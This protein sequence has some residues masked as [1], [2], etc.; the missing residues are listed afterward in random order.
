MRVGAHSLGRWLAA[1]LIVGV[2]VLAYSNSFRGVFVFD[3]KT[4]IG[5]NPAIRRLWPPGEAMFRGPGAPRRP[6]PYYT[7]ALNYALH[8][9]DVWGYHA[10]NLAIH[11]AAGLTL[12]GLVRRT[13]RRPRL[14]ARYAA[15]ADQIA[16]AAALVWVVHPL[17]TQAVTY[18]YQRMESLM[19]LFYLL[20]LYCFVRSVGSA[21]S[22]LWRQV[23]VLCCAAGMGC[24]EVMVT[25]P[26]LVLWYDRVFVAESWREIPRRRWGFYAAMAATWAFLLVVVRC[27]A[28]RYGELT[29]P[30]LTPWQYALNQ[31]AV[32]LHYLRLAVFPRGLCL[33]HLWPAAAPRELVLP[34]LVLAAILAA[35]LWCVVRRPALGFVAGSFFLLLAPTSSILPVYELAFEHRMYLSLAALAV[36]FILGGY[37][38]LHRLAARPPRFLPRRAFHF[39]PLAAV[40]LVVAALAATTYARNDT[41]SSYRGMWRDVIEKAPGNGTAYGRLGLEFLKEHRDAESLALFRKAIEIFAANP[42]GFPPHMRAGAQ[43][44]LG[45][46]LANCGKPA[47]ARQCY[48]EALRIASDFP[49]AYLNL[50]ALFARLHEPAQAKRCFEK[51]I[52]LDPDNATLFL[53]SELQDA[54]MD[55]VLRSLGGPSAQRDR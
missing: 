2:G 49:F 52:E 7:F 37:E 46:A 31:S 5:T 13:L 39:L 9:T 41:Y 28:Y 48:E 24:K 44:N 1:G 32:I 21:R 14:A 35:T 20:T 30:L 12:F 36:M 18:I 3:D 11:L 8:G 19:G 53:A 17:Q 47:E 16:L 25:A 10:V 26:L 29:G 34:S 45:V 43:V 55:V 15:V 42:P 40:G 51:A 23:A 6:L 22:G 38:L 27:Q 50:G 54:E 4:E 33:Y